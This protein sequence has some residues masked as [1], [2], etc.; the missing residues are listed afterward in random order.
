MCSYCLDTFNPR[1]PKDIAPCQIS[2]NTNLYFASAGGGAVE[3]GKHTNSYIWMDYERQEE[4]PMWGSLVSPGSSR[5]PAV[6][7]SI[8]LQLLD[9][10]VRG[11]KH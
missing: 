3:R 2:I 6:S 8:S 9:K 10:V 11:E 1:G 4:G 5:S 7:Q